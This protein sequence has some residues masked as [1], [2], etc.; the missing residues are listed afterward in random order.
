MFKTRPKTTL[1]IILTILLINL[2]NIIKRGADMVTCT[3][4]PSKHLGGR[5]KCIAVFEV[6]QGYIGCPALKR[7]VFSLC[8]W[9]Y[10]CA[11]ISICFDRVIPFP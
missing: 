7:K 4:Y 2:N 3:F 10:I 1:K 8:R 6:S 11:I 5:D 9:D